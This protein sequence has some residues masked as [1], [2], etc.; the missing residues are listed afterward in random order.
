MSQASV[1]HI[2]SSLNVSNAPWRRW[3]TI[4]PSPGDVRLRR[5]V[6]MLHVGQTNFEAM[7]SYRGDADVEAKNK[8]S[9]VFARLSSGYF[10]LMVIT[11]EEFLPV[12]LTDN[13]S[14][15]FAE[16]PPFVR[17]L[18]DDISYTIDFESSDDLWAVARCIAVARSNGEE[19]NADVPD[20]Q[21][22]ITKL[23]AALKQMEK[24][25]FVLAV[26]ASTSDV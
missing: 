11:E 1:G 3:L 25:A 13:V 15:Q 9:V 10:V 16:D 8:A 6:I 23:Q 22:E 2:T 5:C 14:F 7:P 17:W 24:T 12:L 4:Q 21:D 18:Q 20:A 19:N 26:E